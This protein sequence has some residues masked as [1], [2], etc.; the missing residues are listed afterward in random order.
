M[1]EFCCA[2]TCDLPF[3]LEAGLRRHELK[4]LPPGGFVCTHCGKTFVTSADRTAHRA[5]SHKVD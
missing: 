1:S 4:H 3:K 2:Q 5:E